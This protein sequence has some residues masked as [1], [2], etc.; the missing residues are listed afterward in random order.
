MLL[1]ILR[2]SVVYTQRNTN[3]MNFRSVAK[4][5]FRAKQAFRG[6]L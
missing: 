6:Q 2:V 5:T 3:M 4:L 1:M